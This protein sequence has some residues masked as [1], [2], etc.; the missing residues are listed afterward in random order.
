MVSILSHGV[1]IYLYLLFFVYNIYFVVFLWFFHFSSWPSCGWGNAMGGSITWT[2]TTHPAS[3][4]V[5][6]RSSFPRSKVAVTWCVHSP[7]FSTKVKELWNCTSLSHLLFVHRN[8]YKSC[9]LPYLCISKFLATHHVSPYAISLNNVLNWEFILAC[10]VK[11]TQLKL[12]LCCNKVWE[13]ND[14][15]SCAMQI[16]VNCEE[17]LCLTSCYQPTYVNV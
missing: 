17:I 7:L 10:S 12:I 3:S 14:N 8:N 6:T 13:N 5:Y 4:P 15:A 1:N 9:I 11:L 2:T 16:Q